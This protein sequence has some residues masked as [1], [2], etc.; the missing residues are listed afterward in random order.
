MSPFLFNLKLKYDYLNWEE[1]TDYYRFAIITLIRTTQSFG[2]RMK[3]VEWHLNGQA[4]IMIRENSQYF[5][6]PS[7]GCGCFT[8]VQYVPWSLKSKV[9]SYFDHSWCCFHRSQA[10][11]LPAHVDSVLLKRFI[12]LSFKCIPCFEIFAWHVALCRITLWRQ[13][14]FFVGYEKFFIYIFKKYL[15]LF[16]LIIYLLIFSSHSQNHHALLHNIK[17]KIRL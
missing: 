15:K 5:Q 11:L 2:R 17:L 6:K 9:K 10:I 16:Q 7:E 3:K 14:F 1:F 13:Q 12:S 4:H 8:K